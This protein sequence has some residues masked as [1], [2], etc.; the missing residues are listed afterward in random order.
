MITAI[1]ILSLID[2][3][4]TYA[5]V[6]VGAIQ[7]GNPIIAWGFERSI[8]GTCLVAA[9]LI[10]VCLMVLKRYMSRFR[11][12]R[13]VVAGLVGVKAFVVLLHVNWIVQFY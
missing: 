6:S 8:V 13:F 1:A 4:C 7:E 9:V 11:W 10:A 3:A 12:T 2:I 5:G